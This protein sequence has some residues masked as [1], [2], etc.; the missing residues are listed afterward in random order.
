MKKLIF[1][2]ALM[3]IPAGFVGAASDYYLKLGGVE[4]ESSVESTA[5]LEVQSTRTQASTTQK[6]TA[7]SPT[8]DSGTVKSQPSTDTGNNTNWDFGG[9][10][11]IGAKKSASTSAESGEKGGTADINIGI[12]EAKKKG[13]VEFEWKVE[14]GESAPAIEPDEIDVADDGEP[15]TPDMAVLLGGGSDDEAE[16]EANRA[17]VAQIL[18]EGMQEAGAPVESVSMNFEK[19]KTKVV[20]EVKLFGI[21]PVTTTADVEIDAQSKVKVKFPW[22]AALASGKDGDGLG[23]AVFSTLSTILKTKHDTVKNSIGNIR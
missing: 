9:D 1:A 7:T 19:I 17:E 23:K 20:Q 16:A 5:T 12:G 6:D 8:T 2:C 14:E 10:D 13:N 11:S 4:G 21:I 3:L 15:L 18:F 22:W